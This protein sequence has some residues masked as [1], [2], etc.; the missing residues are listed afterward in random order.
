MRNKITIIYISYL[1]IIVKSK[2]LLL[3]SPIYLQCIFALKGRKKNKET[4]F[5]SNN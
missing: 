2:L 3:I 4:I 1:G 5:L